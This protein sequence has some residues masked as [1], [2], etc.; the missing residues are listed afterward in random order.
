MMG[1]Y[2]KQKSD[3]IDFYKG[4][5]VGKDVLGKGE[6]AGHVYA[7]FL[8]VGDGQWNFGAEKYIGTEG[9]CCMFTVAKEPEGDKEKEKD[10]VL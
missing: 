9:G 6:P 3:Q 10:T 2:F 1:E 5:Q 7:W 4:P 8:A